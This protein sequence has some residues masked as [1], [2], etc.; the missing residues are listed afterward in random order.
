MNNPAQNQTQTQI[1]NL[2][3]N[4]NQDPKAVPGVLAKE[5]LTYSPSKIKKPEKPE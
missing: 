3:E 1:Q 5:A 2:A 4:R